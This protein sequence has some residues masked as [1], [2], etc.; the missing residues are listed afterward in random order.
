MLLSLELME[1]PP[2]PVRCSLSLR[3]CVDVRCTYVHAH[4]HT[5][6]PLAMSE[7]K[8]CPGKRDAVFTSS[9]LAQTFIVALTYGIMKDWGEFIASTATFVL[10]LVVMLQMSDIMG[11]MLEPMIGAGIIG[12]A[13]AALLNILNLSTPLDIIY[14]ISDLN[15][16]CSTLETK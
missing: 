2:P 12:Y 15:H 9:C 13:I 10:Y 11:S 7:R 3:L 1:L 6:F 16:R 8:E 14:F 5:L 4:A